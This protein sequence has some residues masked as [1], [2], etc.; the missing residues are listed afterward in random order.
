MAMFEARPL[1][2]VTMLRRQA[3]LEAESKRDQQAF[4]SAAATA[5][6]SSATRISYPESERAWTEGPHSRRISALMEVAMRPEAS[7]TSLPA[8]SIA[9]ASESLTVTGVKYVD[10]NQSLITLRDHYL[11][12][13]VTINYHS[14]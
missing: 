5:M 3:E 7:L 2:Q 6:S 9:L 4:A 10:L 14:V 13:C 8:S 11:S 12:L 1:D